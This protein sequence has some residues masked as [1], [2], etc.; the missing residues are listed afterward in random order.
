[1]RKPAC[2]AVVL[3]V[4]QFEVEMANPYPEGAANAT[5]TSVGDPMTQISVCDPMTHAA[6]TYPR[7]EPLLW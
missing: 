4:P 2:A 5:K 3:A 6:G 1:M 7:E